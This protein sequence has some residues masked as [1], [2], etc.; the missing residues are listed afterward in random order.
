MNG[1]DRI[2]DE[3]KNW[4]ARKLDQKREKREREKI[5]RKKGMKGRKPKKWIR[6]SS[7]RTGG[8]TGNK[9]VLDQKIR[10]AESDFRSEI[11]L[12]KLE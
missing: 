3:E 4:N 7:C 2:F 1:Y 9:C 5:P 8:K 6:K 12:K 11:S 10:T